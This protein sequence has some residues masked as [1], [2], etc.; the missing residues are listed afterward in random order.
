MRLR[1]LRPIKGIAPSKA[2]RLQITA[3]W[4]P[5]VQ[6]GVAGSYGHPEEGPGDHPQVR[7]ARGI[8]PSGP[9]PRSRM[10]NVVVTAAWCGPAGGSTVDGPVG[11]AEVQS[12]D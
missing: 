8:G 10:L 7:G 2:L 1:E 3:P 4:T 9:G 11:P 6:R 5:P 12:E